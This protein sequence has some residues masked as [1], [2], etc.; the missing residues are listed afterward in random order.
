MT[1]FI[2]LLMHRK[3]WVAYICYGITYDF[4]NPIEIR[5]ILAKSID[6]NLKK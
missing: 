1:Q 3:P 2:M 4:F 5:V 6:V